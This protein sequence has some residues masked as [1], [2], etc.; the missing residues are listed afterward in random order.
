MTTHGRREAENERFCELIDNFGGEPQTRA[1]LMAILEAKA[2]PA[3][4]RA[5]LLA[6]SHHLAEIMQN[7]YTASRLYN[8]IIDEL[9]AIE[10]DY[11]DKHATERELRNGLLIPALRKALAA[12]FLEGGEINEA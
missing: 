9:N 12:D 5:Q 1:F 4:E 6:I 2:M 7:D 10:G 3:D 8:V 11:Q